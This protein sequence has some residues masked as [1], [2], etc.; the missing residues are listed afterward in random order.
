VRYRSYV[1][2]GGVWKVF[3]FKVGTDE[4]VNFIETVQ[5]VCFRQR[6]KPQKNSFC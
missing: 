4:A 6:D 2:C 1:G 5:T 3:K